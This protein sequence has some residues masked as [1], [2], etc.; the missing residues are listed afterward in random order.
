MAQAP[1]T[2]EIVADTGGVVT[3]IDALE[4]GLT[5]VAMGA[6]RTRADQAVDHAVGIELC[7]VRGERV[8]P[9]EPLAVLHVRD[10]EAADGWAVRIRQA[11]TIASE[12]EAPPPI[13]IERIG[14]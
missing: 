10:P 1:H 14:S 2:V 6:G 3:A 11:F 4:V 7:A 5:G 12:G 13:V 8:D 9:G